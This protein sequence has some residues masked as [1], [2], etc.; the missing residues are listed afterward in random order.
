MVGKGLHCHAAVTRG[1]RSVSGELVAVLHMRASLPVVLVLWHVPMRCRR[2]A[3]R[4]PT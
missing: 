3:S 4:K 2:A 1:V